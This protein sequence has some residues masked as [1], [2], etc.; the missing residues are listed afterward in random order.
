MGSVG[1]Q[2]LFWVP[3][4]RSLWGGGTHGCLPV[5]SCAEDWSRAGGWNC[6]QSILNCFPWNGRDSADVF[7]GR[8]AG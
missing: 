3:A 8:A 2:V 4:P 7:K 1:S 5:G 6:A